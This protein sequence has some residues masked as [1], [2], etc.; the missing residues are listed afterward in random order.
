MSGQLIHKGPDFAV[1]EAGG[2]GYQVYCGTRHLTDLPALGALVQILTY[3]HHRE[4][5]MLLFGFANVEERELFFLLCGVSGVGAKLAMSLLGAMNAE[6]L[7]N[8]IVDDNPRGLTQ[9]P[10]VGAKLAQ[11]IVL[12]LRDKLAGRKVQLAAP[13]TSSPR[14]SS[15][16]ELALASLGYTATEIQQALARL[17]PQL[18][19]EEAIRRAIVQLSAL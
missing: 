13:A 4:D 1:I 3:L 18:P 12:E 5:T 15:E 9:A 10:G 6:E 17:D 8:A 11:R 19:V 2:V 14:E 16:A 7:A